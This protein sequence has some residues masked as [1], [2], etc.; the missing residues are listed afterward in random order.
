MAIQVSRYN[1]R[2]G[3]SAL[4]LLTETEVFNIAD[5]LGLSCTKLSELHPDV[6]N[7][8]RRYLLNFNDN[9]KAG[10]VIEIGAS[11]SDPF[12]K[13]YNYIS[14]IQNASYNSILS[15]SASSSMGWAD[16]YYLWVDD[17]T[18]LF[19][20]DTSTSTYKPVQKLSLIM[21]KY[22]NDNKFVWL[23]YTDS[24]GYSWGNGQGDFISFQNSS[25]IR[26]AWYSPT[27]ITLAPICVPN[28]DSIIRDVYFAFCKQ[29]NNDNMSRFYNIG[30]E[31]YISM[32]RSNNS[33]VCNMFVKLP[34]GAF[35]DERE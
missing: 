14:E 16:I 13:I 22:G 1:I 28:T 9:D 34:H 23:F 4:R 3:T 12:I 11:T 24:Y 7:A 19:G 18:L 6:T 20:I 26:V 17:D 21:R 32:A 27:T 15:V 10:I 33:D 25:S 30:G 31:N 29:S 8:S 35:D 5:K 2:N